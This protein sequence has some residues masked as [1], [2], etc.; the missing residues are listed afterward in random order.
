MADVV[1]PPAGSS[2]RIRALYFIDLLEDSTPT[3]MSWSK[4]GVMCSTIC[5][6]ATGF[7]A[8]IQAVS[9]DIAHTNWEA[10]VGAIGFHTIT[11]G[12]HE[13]KRRTESK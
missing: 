7:A 13:V 1:A 8:S 2:L 6:A 11:K 3:K 4:V 12:M 9:G 10:L 5:A